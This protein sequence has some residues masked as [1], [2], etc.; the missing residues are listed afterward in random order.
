MMAAKRSQFVSLFA[1]L[2]LASCA[3]E[4]PKFEATLASTRRA[5]VSGE[6]KEALAHFESQ[7]REAEASAASAWFPQ[8]YWEAATAAYRE[9][10][11]AAF[12][13]GQL[14]RSI[15]HGEKALE[16]ARKTNEPRLKLWAV[17]Q[18]IQVYSAVRN[19]DR[20]R[21]FTKEGFEVVTELP[22]NTNPRISWEGAL[23]YKLGLDLMR[24]REY[25]KA[26]DA[27]SRSVNLHENYLADLRSWR[28]PNLTL[29]RTE[30]STLL[31]R[32]TDLGAAYR[33]A[34]K[35]DQA[36]EQYERAFNVINEQG[37]DYAFQGR[38]YEDVG[39]IQRQQKK[40]SQ[41]LE[42]F[43]K[44]LALAEKQGTPG[45]L[46]SA[47]VAIGN[48]LRQT[49]KAREAIPYYQTAIQQV[50]SL[51][52]RLESE[53]YRQSFF[54]GAIGPYINIMLA[55]IA[56]K[57]PAEAFNYNERAR[58]RAFL[59]VLGSKVQLAR[60]GAL[61]EE[62]R[63]LQARIATL[64]ARMRGQEAD[65]PLRPQLRQELE[66][67]QKAYSDFLVRVRNEN[68]EQASLMNVEPLTLK[69]VQE[70]LD[71]GITVL[72]YF[73][74]PQAVLLWV[75]EKD[76]LRFVRI[77]A[78]RG[79]LLS[80][81]ASLRDSIYQL[82]EKAKFATISQELY[83]LLIEP[84]LPHIRGK[85]LLIIP[86]DV[87]HY[88]PFQALLSGQEKYLI[89]DYPI[90]YLSSASL[91][92]FTKEKSRASREN[93][94]VL[95]NP[96]L[97]DEAYNLRF[98]EREA[99]EVARVFPKSTIFLRD[100][101]TKGRAISHSSK[102]DILHFAV[103]GELKE[104]DPLSSGLLLAGDEGQKDGLLKV[105]E[106]FSLNLK[107]DTV[108][109]SACETGLGKITSGD[110]IIGLTR[111]FIYAGAPSVVTTLWKVNDRASYELMR[112]FYTNLK[113]A[114]K[115]EALRQAQLKTMKE[116]PHPFFWAAYG[117]TGEP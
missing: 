114:K 94:L 31:V 80:K 65:A 46:R 74:T 52:S 58:S 11:R 103:H 55:L 99:R 105:S 38:L 49:G 66:S 93:V 78:T 104:D 59:D 76:R 19:F 63:S 7:A 25:D 86:H 53:E 3:A 2:L 117:L 111:A 102:Y 61:L 84:A 89:Q 106:I 44:A 23:Y 87:L 88:L 27:I 97:G 100:Q 45:G 33:Q 50:E 81:V 83:K 28:T 21:Q 5:L 108:V 75:V 9:A 51:R 20:A 82:G 6:I 73:V 92:K 96:S 48:V 85:E 8:E 90:Y 47:S 109:L 71:P 17:D 91:M 24:Q 113:T 1:L 115:S 68:K 67:A 34:G 112:E 30:T 116:F 36:L 40:F 98:A 79:D 70:L 77:A 32:L 54:E 4:Q 69:E 57:N 37:L 12:F 39:E 101:A 29:L 35:L 13:A 72:E 43:K 60:G 14:Q 62:E 42:N 64:Q 56:T 22:P 110:E 18:L 15:A 41:A 107:A 95:G 26:I 10:S 16:I